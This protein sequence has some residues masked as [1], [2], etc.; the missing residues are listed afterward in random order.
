MHWCIFRYA[1][2]HTI[3][4]RERYMKHLERTSLRA[5]SVETQKI[6]LVFT[7]AIC[8]GIICHASSYI[9]TH[10]YYLPPPISFL[11]LSHVHLYILSVDKAAV[12]FTQSLS[13]RPYKR[14]YG[15][16]S[17]WAIFSSAETP[18]AEFVFSPQIT[19]TTSQPLILVRAFSFHFVS[20]ASLI[21]ISVISNGESVFF[22]CPTNN[23]LRSE[24]LS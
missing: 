15:T 16:F 14:K 9:F 2:M 8:S 20:I 7:D 3:Y 17:S 22:A 4:K 23:T 10:L 19:I 6:Y 21:D 5:S 12:G 13:E 11:R 18:V 1:P 24:S